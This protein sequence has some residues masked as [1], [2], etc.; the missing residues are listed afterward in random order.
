MR[1][2][3]PQLPVDLLFPTSRWLP[4]TKNINEYVKALHGC[5]HDAIHAARISADQEAARHKR[6][7]D[8]RAGVAELSPGDK[9]LVKLDGYWGARQKLVNQWS[10]TLHTVVRRVADDV[11]AYVI[12]NAKGDHKVLHR[13]QLL[14]WSS[15][16][17]DQEGLQMTV[18]QLTIFV[19]L[20][21]LEPLPEGEKRCIVPYEWSITGF[22]LNL[23]IFKPMLEVSELKTGPEAPATCMDKPPQ[24]EVGQQRKLREET[25]SMGDGDTVLEGML[26]LESGHT[27]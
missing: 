13:A 7:Y 26:C 1:G 5:L 2:C 4:K 3:R 25:K 8:Q 10:S 9:V 11:P 19:S 22:G 16:D 27:E 23:A 18:D 17:E 20:S 15:C 14:L 6:L 12:E 21:A 24:E